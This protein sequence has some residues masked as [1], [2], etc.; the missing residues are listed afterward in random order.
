MEISIIWNVS[1]PDTYAYFP[2][3]SKPFT[4]E[5]AVE[6]ER[7]LI[8]TGSFGSEISIIPNLLR[9]LLVT[10]AYFPAISIFSGAEKEIFP[11]IVGLERGVCK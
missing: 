1:N 11:S 7:V 3:I 9:L 8:S 4:K 10:Y 5:N 6:E 2:A